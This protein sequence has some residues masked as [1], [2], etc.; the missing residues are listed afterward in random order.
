[1]KPS[2]VAELA[3]IGFLDYAAWQVNSLTG[4]VFS[5]AVLLFI[6]YVIEDDKALIALKK[7]LSAVKSALKRKKTGGK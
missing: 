4:L 6:G 2:D 1:V 7:P 5:G 3:G